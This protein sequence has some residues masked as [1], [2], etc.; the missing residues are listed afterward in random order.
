MAPSVS[1][2]REAEMGDL[3]AVVMGILALKQSGVWQTLPFVPNYQHVEAQVVMMLHQ[4]SHRLFV[5]V[6]EAMV[7]GLCGVELVQQRFI[8]DLL[9]VLEWALWVR[10]ERRGD[11]TGRDLWRT[12]CAWGRAQGAHGSIRATPWAHGERRTMSMW[13]DT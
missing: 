1:L 7:M 8:P 4:T 12:A 6:D 11:G 2:I 5:A 10:P 9:F 3:H 13:E